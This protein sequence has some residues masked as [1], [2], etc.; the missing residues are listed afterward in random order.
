MFLVIKIDQ[1]GVLIFF[2]TVKNRFLSFWSILM[3]KNIILIV[4]QRVKH[5]KG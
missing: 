3:T 4:T 2:E 5:G 1:N